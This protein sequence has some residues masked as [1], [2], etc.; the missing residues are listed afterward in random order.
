MRAV[1]GTVAATAQQGLP[2][3]LIA[4]GLFLAC[5]CYPQSDLEV[6]LADDVLE[7][8]VA[9]VVSIERLSADICVLRLHPRADYPYRAG[10]FLQLACGELR[11]NYS[12]ASVPAL[13]ADLALHVRRLPTGL[14][15]ARI[16][17]RLQPGDEVVISEPRGHCVYEPDSPLQNLLLI[18][19]GCGLAPLSAIVRD[20]LHQGHRGR[21]RLYHGSRSAAGLYLRDVLTGLERTHGNLSYHPCLSQG[22]VDDGELAGRALDC[23]LRDNP[24]LSGWRAYLCG[25]PDMVQAAQ[26]Q[27]FLAGAGSS[28]I[29]ADPFLPTGPSPIPPP[30]SMAATNE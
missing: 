18:G 9:R 25:N 3:A 1:R 23:A 20:A 29:F 28:E 14:M 16:F 15:G 10:Q 7:H 2:A 6:A 21:I 30:Q 12:L 27:C 17:E 5:Q 19:T 22:P 11:R 8:H 24:D 13:D 4:R 26:L